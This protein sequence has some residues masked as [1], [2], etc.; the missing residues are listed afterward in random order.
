[1]LNLLRETQFYLFLRSV[2]NFVTASLSVSHSW[3]MYRVAG[4]EEISDPRVK[5]LLLQDFT[6][7]TRVNA[8]HVEGENHVFHV[9]LSIINHGYKRHHI[10]GFVDVELRK[11]GRVE[12]IPAL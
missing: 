2:R 7:H 6:L 11:I 1:M 3:H 10:S 4:S 9:P 5:I 8:L 12:R